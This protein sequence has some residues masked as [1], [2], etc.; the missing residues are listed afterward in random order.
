MRSCPP[1]QIRLINQSNGLLFIYTSSIDDGDLS[2]GPTSTT[3]TL[4]NSSSQTPEQPTAKANNASE[5]R[6]IIARSSR[7]DS[8]HYTCQATNKH[9]TDKMAINLLVQDVPD[10]VAELKVTNVTA[11]T[12]SLRWQLAFAG[13]SPVGSYLVQYQSDDPLD[14]LLMSVTRSMSAKSTGAEDSIVG[15]PLMPLLSNLIDQQQQQSATSTAAANPTASLKAALEA[16]SVASATADEAIDR[17]LV[18]L[19][20]EQSATNLVVK[21]LSPFC[22]YRLRLAAINKIGLGEFSDWIRAKTEEAPPSGSA[23]K[24]SA[25][26][27]GPNSIKLTWFPPDRRAWNGQLVRFNIGYRPI[28]SAFE[29]N[30]TLEWSPPSLQSIM[31][32]TDGAADK[33]RA[34]SPA[35]ANSTS[36][37]KRP[38][39]EGS[40]SSPY[41]LRQHLRQLLALQQ[42]ELVAHL[43]NLQRSTTYLVWIQ[44]VN[45]RGSGPQSHA[46]TVK[47]L[48]DV[49]PSA[50]ALRIQS[51]SANSIS[52]AWSMLSNFV[53]SANQY[54]L[55][56]R[57]VPP[58]PSPSP[59]LAPLAPLPSP[60]TT[61]IGG[62]QLAANNNNNN[63][64]LQDQQDSSLSLAYFHE[65]GPFIERTISSQ[66]LLLSGGN[67]LQ[68]QVDLMQQDKFLQ[69]QQSQHYQQFVYTLDQLDCGSVYE[70]Y[71]TTR[72]SVGKSEPSPVVTTRTRGEPPLA[73]ADKNALFSRIGAS[74][75]LLNLATWSTGGCP[76]T[77]ITVKYKQ[78]PTPLAAAATNSHLNASTQMVSSP[79]SSGWPISASVP[80]NLLGTINNP[81]QPR[82]PYSSNLASPAHLLAGDV[83]LSHAHNFEHPSQQPQAPFSLKNLLPS[84]GYE[85]EI[86]AYN[87]AGHTMAQ[88]EF[89]T[90]GVNGSRSGY[91][92]RDGVYRLDQRGQPL[93]DSNLLSEQHGPQFDASNTG[94]L[95]GQLVPLALTVLC[96]VCLII[97]STFCYYRLADTW[98]RQRRSSC[99]G[100]GDDGRPPANLSPGSTIDTTKSALNWARANNNNHHYHHQTTFNRQLGSHNELDDQSS[101]SSPPANHVHYCTRDLTSN[102]QLHQ[103]QQQQLLSATLNPKSSAGF[104]QSVSMKDFN[105]LPSPMG[106]AST[107]NYKTNC[108]QQRS[109]TGARLSGLQKGNTL[110]GR[111]YN[112][113]EMMTTST[114]EQQ[115]H[116]AYGNI[117]L[118][119]STYGTSCKNGGQR[120]VTVRPPNGIYGPGAYDH[121]QTTCY[122]DH[123]DTSWTTTNGHSLGA[124]TNGTSAPTT[125]TYA[126]P[127][128]AYQ[129]NDEA[130]CQERQPMYSGQEQHTYGQGSIDACIQHLIG[131]Q[132]Q[133]TS[134]NNP[135]GQQYAAILMNGGQQ[136]KQLGYGAD[137]LDFGGQSMDNAL[138]Q[139]Q[140]DTQSNLAG[141]SVVDS[142]SSS[143]GIGTSTISN[144]QHHL[145]CGASTT[146]A[147]TSTNQA[148]QMVSMGKNNYGQQQQQSSAS[149]NGGEQSMELKQM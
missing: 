15:S 69:H 64:Q 47:T 44:A 142:S 115:P 45:N 71:M 16:L 37:S 130:Q 17:T 57:R 39:Q 53:S 77:H 136:L 87:A 46:I 98:K 76:M 48:D 83:A 22:V 61:S 28:D 42:Q 78:T 79:S 13:N 101:S 146:T 147:A 52:I 148:Y 149:F 96:F 25:A 116:V 127:T 102:H 27:T 139:Q 103:Q 3:S 70:L 82:T 20:V 59:S 62:R 30:K 138:G 23:L 94:S 114:D 21:D 117:N 4:Q 56:Y 68:E 143:S 90:A 84:T 58:P 107:L 134:D 63:S 144:G 54:S 91:T 12:I 81:S 133:P 10:K 60:L 104:S 67:S 105:L 109:S 95:S 40:S 128:A 106:V 108:G 2:G 50:P 26:A 85:L 122:A 7:P 18:E 19:T 72:N 137:N 120:L 126:I 6:L 132:Y 14:D 5:S 24:I 34:G 97:S 119:C 123:H 65:P 49:P 131:Q 112:T 8:G 33:R 145:D 121:S 140:Q 99:G 141:Q 75:V 9:G 31:L 51:T 135:N 1:N 66:Q 55:F 111:L 32:A 129:A 43:T 110:C 80:A 93:L 125:T 36:S 88:Y 92:R 113:N 89:V 74:D 124:A 73:P 118:D 86:I 11:T 100:G 41:L 38:A 29:F 35:G